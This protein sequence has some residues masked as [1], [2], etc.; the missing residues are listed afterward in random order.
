MKI[1]ASVTVKIIAFKGS[2]ISHN[3]GQF[4]L[5]IPWTFNN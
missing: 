3:L 5:I 2:N 1:I 4:Y